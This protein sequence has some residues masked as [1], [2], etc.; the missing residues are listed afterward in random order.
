MPLI[1][2]HTSAEPPSEADSATFLLEL[3]STLARV[4]G[5]PEAYVMTCLVPRSR[6]TFAGTLE[7]SCL[8]EI[9]SIGGLSSKSAREL[10]DATCRLA[11]E[12]L[13]VQT[14]RTYVVCADVPAHLWGFDGGTFG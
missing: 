14:N 4:L 9:K 3:S 5:K 12:R 10:S 7:P 6:M 2:V 11:R 13:G 1:T 8:V